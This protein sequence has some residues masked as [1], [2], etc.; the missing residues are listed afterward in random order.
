LEAFFLFG[1]QELPGHKEVVMLI[2]IRCRDNPLV[3]AQL[4]QYKG[5]KTPMARD[6][7]AS[8]TDR[9]TQL[10]ILYGSI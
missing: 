4:I 3:R 5:D 10:R 8:Y 9:K 7:K 2:R 1:I 6:P